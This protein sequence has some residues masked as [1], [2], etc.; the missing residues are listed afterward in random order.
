MAEQTQTTDLKTTNLQ[1]SNSIISRA[2][3]AI[4]TFSKFTSEPAVQRSI[5]VMITPFLI[6]FGE[7]IPISSAL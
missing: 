1:N 2:S 7:K 5:P 3:K 4:D 6:F